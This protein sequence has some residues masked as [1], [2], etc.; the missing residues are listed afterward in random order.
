MVSSFFEGVPGIERVKPLSVM[1]SQDE[2]EGVDDGVDDG[3]EDGVNPGVG[4]STATRG[5]DSD[6][7]LERNTARPMPI[8]KTTTPPTIQGTALL[9]RGCA[10]EGGIKAG[11]GGEVG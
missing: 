3:V 6:L 8:I 4:F 11:G 7:R 5:V 9:R 2:D 1:V 10:Y